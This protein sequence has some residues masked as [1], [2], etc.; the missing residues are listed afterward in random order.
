MKTILQ[1]TAWIVIGAAS[2]LTIQK[3]NKAVTLEGKVKA[4]QDSLE[5]CRVAALDSLFHQDT[6]WLEFVKYHTRYV[7]KYV[8]KPD[9]QPRHSGISDYTLPDQYIYSDTVDTKD[10]KLYYAARVAGEM[11]SIGF[12]YKMKAPSVITKIERY[13]EPMQAATTW[14]LSA[15]GGLQTKGGPMVGLNYTG[16]NRWGVGLYASPASLSAGVTYRIR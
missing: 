4:Y 2:V 13:P 6:V 5:A 11:D 1:L 10:F 7:T 8:A 16:V 12:A 3:C 15:Y 14:H 9:T